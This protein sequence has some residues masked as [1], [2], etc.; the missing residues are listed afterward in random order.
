MDI[1]KKN[2]R[3]TLFLLG[4]VALVWFY[5][6]FD[7]SS[8]SFKF[9]P[10]MYHLKGTTMGVVSYNIKYLEQ[11]QGGGAAEGGNLASN[12]QPQIDDLLARFN[13]SLSHYLPDSEISA[14]N[15][16]DSGIV[17]SAP[18][19]YPV[20]KAS[21]R[22]YRKTA[23]AFDP[24]IS[25][26][27][28]AWGF[29]PKTPPTQ[30][31]S[32]TLDSLRQLVGFDQ[33]IFTE[34]MLK[35]RNPAITLNLSAIAKGYAVDVVADFLESKG[36]HNYM[37]EIGREVRCKGRNAK[38]KIWRIG[39]MHPA[40]K[41]QSAPQL[42]GTITLDKAAMATSGNY[43]NFYVKD[44]KKYAHTINP[45]TG[46]PVT[47]NLLSASVVAAD[48]MSAD[49]YATALMVMG[50]EKAKKILAKDPKLE[51]VLVYEQNG[52]LK[53]YVSEKL[54]KLLTKIEK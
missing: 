11:K 35:K 47:H 41:S 20:L 23:G 4:A 25:P 30:I 19:F 48:C 51:G 50:T 17:L 6:N 36:V 45:T 52:K 16:S 33:I 40:Y 5:R 53:T 14:F 44:G 27:I 37:V 2:L 39:I 26:L 34:K 12:Y 43:E 18:F 31:D 1:R 10:K 21:A 46:Y 7:F 9:S 38:N 8:G 22:I 49:A 15:R 29:G 24:T 13:A 28:D 54:E 42:M 3:Y 32:L